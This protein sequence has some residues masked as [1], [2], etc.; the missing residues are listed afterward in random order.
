MAELTYRCP[1]EP[2][3]CPA[4]DEP[5]SCEEHFEPWEFMPE[6]APPAAPEAGTPDGGTAADAG[7]GGPGGTGTEIALLF[8]GTI[9]PVPPEGMR[10]GRTC[11]PWKTVPGFADLH[12]VSREHA[13][14]DWRDGV[15]MVT[16]L[17]STN[18]TYVDGTEIAEPAP[19]RPGAALRLGENVHL[20]VAELDE[21]GLPR[22]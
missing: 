16:D 12:Q 1:V 10:I 8:E 14:L 13:R 22:T 3:S 17:T 4:G 6:Y 15:L 19:L 18:G 7:T 5:G 9:L 2:D 11:S 20:T 21:F